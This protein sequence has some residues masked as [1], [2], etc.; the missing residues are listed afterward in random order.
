M[1]AE[2]IVP[3][4]LTK[5]QLMS[6]RQCPRRLW[7]ETH[8]S[9]IVG[10]DS[11]RE[12]QARQARSLQRT[13][14]SLYPD[15][16]QISPDLSGDAAFAETRRHIAQSPAIPLLGARFRHGSLR[17]RA[18]LYR[19]GSN[20]FELLELKSSTRVKAHHLFDVAI[21]TWAIRQ[22]ACRVDRA[23]IAHVDTRFRYRGDKDYRGLL[24]EVDVSEQITPLLTEIPA[25][26]RKA[27]TV[28]QQN[29]EP[30][31][32][33]GRH[34]GSPYPCPFRDHCLSPGPEYPVD[35]LPGAGKLTA[36]LHA[37]GF[38]DLRA[39][40]EERLQK[41][42]HRRIWRSTVSGRPFV[43]PSLRRLLSALPYP[44]AYLD[45][46]AIQFAVP[47]WAD[48]R[49]YEPL[50]FQWSC[51]RETAPGEATHQDFLDTSGD[52]PLH[53][54]AIELLQ[55]LGTA[56][57]VFCYGPFERRVIHKLAARFAALRE[58]LKAAAVRLVDLQPL[59]RAHYYHPAMKGSFSIKAILP[60]LD[61]QFS[62]ATLGVVRDG[63]AAQLAYSRVIDRE[64]DETREQSA[65]S[66]LRAY[67]RLDTLTMLE[68]VHQMQH[69]GG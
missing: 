14:P 45:F 51:H 8:R 32:Q 44:R 24:R 1:P 59:V 2:P 11:T 65:V 15:G 48:T 63:I 43:D 62:Y 28:L 6:A 60:T 39:V 42:L 27:K 52:F 35:L 38:D 18:D 69:H 37:E 23:L 36:R 56:G 25:L 55:A 20:G 16:A 10:E 29:E 53:D 50:P 67:C 22:T 58:P 57:P 19:R 47:R 40:P 26:V 7:L 21:Q 61:G 5:S 66:A 9:E 17:I 46:E 3:Q 31:V 64:L 12:W 33:P 34:C 68:F 49:P 41:P 54:A 4:A 13:L 30:D